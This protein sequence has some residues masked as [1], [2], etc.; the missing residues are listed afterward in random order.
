MQLERNRTSSESQG[1]GATG[2]TLPLWAK[3]QDIQLDLGWR[4]KDR[5]ITNGFINIIQLLMRESGDTSRQLY[6][7]VCS[8]T[9][10]R[11]KALKA[12][13]IALLYLI[14]AETKCPPRRDT[15]ATRSPFS[16]GRG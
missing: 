7:A 3:E 15:H 9:S 8:T 12:L 5:R 4:G 16:G 2:L 10:L 6:H 14:F 11:P 1:S 13:Y